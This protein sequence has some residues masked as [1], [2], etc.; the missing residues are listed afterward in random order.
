MIQCNARQA[1][2]VSTQPTDPLLVQGE[3]PV[4]PVAANEKSI[5]NPPVRS[6]ASADADGSCEPDISKILETISGLQR[7]GPGKTLVIDTCVARHGL[8]WPGGQATAHCANR[9]RSIQGEI[10]RR[11]S[12]PATISRRRQIYGSRSGVF[13]IR[14]SRTG[15]GY[16]CAKGFLETVPSHTE[17]K[18][19]MGPGRILV[20]EAGGLRMEP[21][22]HGAWRHCLYSGASAVC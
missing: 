12:I 18:G 14:S 17:F 15:C 2:E 5:S 19:W 8:Q 20:A 3:R 4:I 10:T 1:Q 11:D 16:E 21:G 7:I 6:Y 22:T 9:S 13:C